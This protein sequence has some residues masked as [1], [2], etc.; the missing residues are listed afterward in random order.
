M[1]IN[2]D[3][4]KY[5]NRYSSDKGEYNGRTS[6]KLADKWRG[7]W[8]YNPDKFQGF[9][10]EGD[11]G[12]AVNYLSNFHFDDIDKQRKLNTQIEELKRI[13]RINNAIYNS[14]KD[15]EV[16]E[17]VKFADALERGNFSK[18]VTNSNKLSAFNKIFSWRNEPDGNIADKF[19]TWFNRL[20]S[21][22]SMEESKIA[23][24]LSVT[25]DPKVQKNIFGWDSFA[26]DNT[27]TFDKFLEN[28]GVNVNDLQAAGVKINIDQNDSV[29]GKTTI[30]FDKTNPYA[31]KMLLAL[32]SGAGG[33]NYEGD[34]NS[35]LHHVQIKGYNGKGE[36][37]TTNGYGDYDSLD[38]LYFMQNIA[39]DAMK[40]KSNVLDGSNGEIKYYTSTVG[41]VMNDELEELKALHNAGYID[42]KQYAA[43][44]QLAGAKLFNAF[45]GLGSSN[46]RMYSNGWN[47]DATD[48]RLNELNNEQRAEAQAAITAALRNPKSVTAQA[49]VSDGEYGVLIT[50]DA[51]DADGKDLDKNSTLSDMAKTR[52]F[53]VFLPGFMSKEVQEKLDANTSTRAI[54]EVNSM[55]D[56]GY[57][58]EL[59]NG[60]LLKYNGDGTFNLSD[61][62]GN[63]IDNI[64]K[65]KAERYI[66]K[67]MIVNTSTEALIYQ[68]MNADGEIV[69]KEGYEKTARLIALNAANELYPDLDMIGDPRSKEYQESDIFDKHKYTRENTQYQMWEKLSDMYDIYEHILAELLKYN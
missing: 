24:S 60:N 68:H 23:R 17:Q 18:L 48:M 3:N 67:S 51:E 27:N 69:D 29:N 30:T 33:T 56:Y 45:R 31:I 25:F 64:S 16:L 4:Y 8:A 62:K 5:I 28:L 7:D 35:I 66:N 47:E 49:M 57:A 53:K 50:I 46:Q 41:P 2:F 19:V 10:N 13:G 39:K 14:I 54:N 15:P 34:V 61:S 42:D 58:Y 1:I 21:D 37:I 59:E 20:G 11:Y 22:S 43:Q 40:A 38:V 6:N 32:D 63:K 9:L 52:E 36:E 26:K 12:G 65:D 55:Q 44:S